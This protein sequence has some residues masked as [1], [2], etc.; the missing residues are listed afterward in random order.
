M[1]ILHILL[2]NSFLLFPPPL[3]PHFLSLA[4]AGF[5]SNPTSASSAML[6][7]WA[8]PP[9]LALVLTNYHSDL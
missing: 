6:C 7:S 9:Q 4:S 1:V 2:E 8:Q 3:P 5:K